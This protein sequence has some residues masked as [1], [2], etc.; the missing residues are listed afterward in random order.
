IR[1]RWPRCWRPDARGA[2][3]RWHRSG[4]RQG[5]HQGGRSMEERRLERI[6]DTAQRSAR[7]IAGDA[8]DMASRAGRSAQ[9]RAQELAERAGDANDRVQRLTGRTTE[10][11][12]KDAQCFVKEHPLQAV[13]LTVGL[14]FVLGKILAR[15]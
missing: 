13:A 9:E 12:M 5:Q 10:S 2:R 8:Q 3:D 11:W 14:G 4:S 15:D 7:R 1:N 6:T